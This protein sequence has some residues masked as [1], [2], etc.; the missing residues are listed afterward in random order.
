MRLG[1]L[2]TGDPRGRRGARAIDSQTTMAML[3]FATSFEVEKINISM[4]VWGSLDALLLTE[5]G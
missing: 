2:R 4:G 5:K 3:I 1:K